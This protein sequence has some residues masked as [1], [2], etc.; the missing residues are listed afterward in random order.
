MIGTSYAAAAKKN[1]DGR[2][3][4]QTTYIGKNV[5]FNNKP[6]FQNKP[7]R[8]SYQQKQTFPMQ[9]SLN[10]PENSY[11]IPN[12]LP[13][14]QGYVN[15]RRPEL[16]QNQYP[17]FQSNQTQNFPNN[18]FQRVQRNDTNE[19]NLRSNGFLYRGNRQPPNRLLQKQTFKL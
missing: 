16:G 1:I 9:G 14:N 10:R 2:R 11:P 7:G 17:G 3:D 4:A 5:R 19:T 8:K 18:R 6:T 13:L 12:P 15:N